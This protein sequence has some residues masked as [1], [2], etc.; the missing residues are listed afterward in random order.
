MF[1]SA[2]L[3]FLMRFFV[4]DCDNTIVF[5]SK[6]LSAN[7]S[8]VVWLPP[9]S[10]SGK[11]GYVSKDVLK[12]LECISHNSTIICASGMRQSTMLQRQ[13]IFSS[14]RYWICEN[15]GRI[16][17][18]LDNGD[19]EEILEWRNEISK[20]SS[21]EESISALRSLSNY[22]K[23]LGWSVDDNYETMIRLREKHDKNFSEIIP[24]IPG[25]LKYT[26]N[27]GYLDIHLPHCDKLTSSQWLMNLLMKEEITES[28]NNPF[29][30]MGDDDNDIV[31]ASAA[32][33]AFITNP[34]SARMLE[35]IK[36][37]DKKGV[38]SH[39]DS[40]TP[41]I[42]I[43]RSPAGNIY[44]SKKIDHLSASELLDFVLHNSDKL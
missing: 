34:C 9:S 4:T 13:A 17:Q 3:H 29:Y 43:D 26:Y 28:D 2:I 31:I 20:I 15:G 11:L 16:F 25:T 6:N 22:F 30:F 23:T 27:L 7:S 12:N 32:S 1:F 24:F 5:Y 21:T 33:A 14:I 40:S 42:C 38:L 41:I 36:S 8:D 37:Q 39:E 18:R 10:G 19:M 35:F 44:L